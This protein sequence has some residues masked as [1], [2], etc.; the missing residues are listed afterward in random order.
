MLVFIALWRLW[1]LV[2]RREI[3]RTSLFRRSIIDLTALAV[4]AWM[5][6]GFAT[7]YVRFDRFIP[8]PISYA[9]GAGSMLMGVCLVGTAAG[10]QFWRAIP[11]HSIERRRFLKAA[12]AATI[13]APAVVTAF[14]ILRRRDFEL[15]HVRV[16]MQGLPKDL[17]GLRLVQLSDIHMSPWLGAADVRYVVDM[18]NETKAHVA[19]VTGDL[20]TRRGDPLDAC[21][22][23][24]KRL[25][26]DAGVLGCL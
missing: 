21:L 8:L 9:L 18:A 25:R 20:I 19:L 10:V 12:R 5:V 3:V 1:S 4:A 11:A 24:L 16:P 6:A 2:R 13:A 14:G 7:H 26:A 23:E 22:N 17:D 15:N